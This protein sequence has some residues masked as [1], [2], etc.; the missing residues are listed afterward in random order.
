LSEIKG[1]GPGG[2]IIPP[3]DIERERLKEIKS[4]VGKIAFT[5]VYGNKAKVSSVTA[6]ITKAEGALKWIEEVFS[7]EEWKNS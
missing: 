2:P 5:T 3:D 4:R 6:G 7:K 1:I